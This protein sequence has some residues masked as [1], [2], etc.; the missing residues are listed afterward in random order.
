MCKGNTAKQQNL[1]KA[2]GNATT[3]LAPGSS[4]FFVLLRPL[5]KPLT[6]TAGTASPAAHHAWGA[7]LCG[8]QA[9]MFRF[10]F[11]QQSWMIQGRRPSTETTPCA[12]RTQALCTDPRDRGCCLIVFL[13]M[14]PH[15]L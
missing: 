12:Y 7:I 4:S 5:T 13:L 10:V 11:L 8:P 1:L 15:A 2:F 6:M 14:S 9:A 3:H